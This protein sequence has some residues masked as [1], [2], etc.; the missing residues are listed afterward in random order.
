MHAAFFND[1]HVH[2]FFIHALLCPITFTSVLSPLR[3]HNAQQ[4]AVAAL[5]APVGGWD[6]RDSNDLSE[7]PSIYISNRDFSLCLRHQMGLG[8]IPCKHLQ[9]DFIAHYLHNFIAHMYT[10]LPLGSQVIKK[11]YFVVL[12]WDPFSLCG[13]E[14]WWVP[15][16]TKLCFCPK[17]A[18]G[19]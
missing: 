9:W 2:Y 19:C 12:Q 15:I 10:I 13:G 17:N 4:Q 3:P 18:L 7:A 6:L 5:S 11:I 14:G 1:R 8:S 16:L